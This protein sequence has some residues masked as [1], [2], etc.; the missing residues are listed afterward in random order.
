MSQLIELNLVLK[1]LASLTKNVHITREDD[2]KSVIP[3]HGG[4]CKCWIK[5]CPRAPSIF[6]L[7]CRLGNLYIYEI[8]FFLIESANMVK[9]SSIHIGIA[10]VHLANIK[11]PNR[12]F[13]NN[14]NYFYKTKILYFA[15]NTWRENNLPKSVSEAKSIIPRHWKDLEKFR[16]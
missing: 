3:S 10:E 14:N 15:D 1:F 9:T 11:E 7:H 6:R 13:S 4:F 12:I 8:E 5:M 2:T 16:N